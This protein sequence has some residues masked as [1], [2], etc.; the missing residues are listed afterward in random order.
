M[1]KENLSAEFTVCVRLPLDDERENSIDDELGKA[2]DRNPAISHM[3][4]LCGAANF[5][6]LT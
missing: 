2:A 1:K 5:N 4:R 3:S 6:R